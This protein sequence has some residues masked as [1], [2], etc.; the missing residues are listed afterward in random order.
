M[1]SRLGQRESVPDVARVLSRY[2]DVIMARVFGHRDVVELA[3]HSRV[4]VINGLSDYTHPCQG[5]ADLLTIREKF[6]TLAGHQTGLHR[7]WQQ[8][9]Q[10]ADLRR[11]AQRH[12]VRHRLAARL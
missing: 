1:K 9:R 7:R 6:G 8:R 11:G 5:L 3:Q 4:P 12:D 10:F 2:V